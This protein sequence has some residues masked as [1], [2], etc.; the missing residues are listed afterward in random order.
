MP[1]GERIPQEFIDELVARTDIVELI[2]SRVPLRKASHNHVACCPF[3]NEKTPSFTVSPQK[4][5]YYCFGCGVHGTAIGFLMAFDRLSFIEAVEE[6]AQRAGMIVPQSSK[7]QDYYNRHQG[8]Y[9]VLAC[10]AEFYQQQLEANAYQGQVKAYLRE[11]GLSGSVIAEFGLGFAPPRWNA[12]LHY[13]QPSLKS[14]LQAAGLAISK[15]ENRYYDRF[16]DRLIFPIHDYRGRVIGFGG[17]LLGNGSPKYLNSPETPLFHKGREL[18]GLY[19]VR[20]SLR[21]CD[22]LLVVEGYMDVLALAEH[23]IR[24]A[25]ATLG[26]ATTSDHLTRLFRITP[27]VIFCFDGD[28]AGYQAAW[29]ALET[30]LPLLGQGRQVQFMFLP[31]GEDPDTVVRAEG[32]MA[33]EARITKAMPLSDFLLNNLRQKVDLSSVDGRAR[34][35]EL[36]QPLLARIPPGVYQDMLLAHLAELAQLEQATLIRHLR[37]GKKPMA[38]PPL[39]RLERGAA[40]PT[41]RAVAILLQRPKMIQ[42]VD[43]NLSLRE[44]EGAGVELLQKLINLLRNNPYLNTAALLERWRDSE[45]GRYLEQLAGWELLLT[46]EDMVLELQAALERLQVQGAEQRIIILSNQ[47]SLTG[48][49]QRELLALLAEK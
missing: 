19:Q 44:L 6:L 36:A 18:Y 4:Q 12:L 46:D 38:V 35:V 16:R 22:R 31:Q 25:V 39:Q 7:Q 43:K 8:L 9:E 48:A 14:H 33:F 13:T 37:P 30:A 23:K 40:S 15:G 5:F 2:D 45:M 28:R 24:Y 41:R 10:A 49:E 26:T 29:R 20:K 34:L 17:R 3:H 32:Q 21:R 42:W 47:S 27:A 1:M 11:R